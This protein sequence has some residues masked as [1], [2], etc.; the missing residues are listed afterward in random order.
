M[1]TFHWHLGIAHGAVT[2]TA[3]CGLGWYIVVFAAAIAIVGLIVWK[4][5]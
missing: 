2:E 5:A 3:S 4:T 1:W